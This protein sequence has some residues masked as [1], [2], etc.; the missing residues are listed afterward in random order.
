MLA[1]YAFAIYFLHVAVF[2][3]VLEALI[4][5]GGK[6]SPVWNIITVPVIWIVVLAISLGIAVLVRKL[7]GKRSR[8]IIGA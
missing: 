5:L 2:V 1:T 4:G 6:I 7:A 8:M 3:V